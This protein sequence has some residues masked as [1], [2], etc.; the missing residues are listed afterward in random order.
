MAKLFPPILEGT[1]PAFYSENGIVKITIPFSMNR[2]VSPVQVKGLVL[3]IKTVQSSSYL[4]TAQINNELYFDLENSP[5]VEFTFGKDSTNTEEN[6]FINNLKVGQ[7]YKFQLAYLG[8][9]D[10]VGHYS[11]VAIGK[12]TTKPNLYINNLNANFINTHEYKYI[13][14]YS[15]RNGDITERVYSYRFDIYDYN[16]KIIATSGEQLHNSS[17]DTELDESY[18]EF[19]FSQDLEL[20]KPYRVKYT[21]TTVN[22]LTISSYRYR[23]MQ[24][25]TIDPEVKASLKASANYDN[26]YINVSLIGDKDENGMEE[27]ATGAFL[28]TRACEDSNYTIWDEISR[29]KLATQIPSRQLWRDYTIEQGK[30]YIYSLQQYNDNGLYSNRMLSNTVFG[31]FEDAFLFDGNRQLKIKY[32][33]KMSNFKAD[34][35]ET[36]IDTI[37][38]KHP[39][40]FRNGKVYYREFAISGLISY[41]MDEENLFLSEEESMIKEKTTNLTSEN[42]AQERNFKMKVYEWLTDGKPKLFRSPSEGN[43][44]VRL[45][46]VSM[47]PN[48]T[49][50]RMLHTFNA[51]AYEIAE[52][53]YENLNE[54]D[55]IHLKDPEVPQLRWETI[56]FNERDEQGKFV[57]LNGKLNKHPVYTVR[58]VDMIPGDQFKIILENDDTQ[59]IQ[60]GVTGSYYIDLGV[61]IKS[62]ELIINEKNPLLREGSMTYSYYSIQSNI[63]DKISNVTVSEVP[64]R[65]FI[66]HHDV[67]KE[68]EYV[69]DKENDKWYKNPK[70][71]IIE[72]YN[73]YASKRTNEKIIEKDNIYY[74]DKDCRIPLPDSKD[75]FTLYQVGTWEATG[76]GSMGP[77]YG[78][79]R[80]TYKFTIKS[81]KDFFNDKEYLISSDVNVYQPFI[82]INNSQISLNDTQVFTMDKPGKLSS[83]KSGNGTVVEV[84]YQVRN[85]DYNIEDDERNYP[86]LFNAKKDYLETLVDFE[87]YLNDDTN[88]GEQS[89]LDNYQKD[90]NIKYNKYILELIKAQEEEK[91]AEGLI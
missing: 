24:K 18:D 3:K 30:N 78:P 62:I 34:I 71:D 85:I 40:I 90:L 79:S 32:N 2:A 47:T 86:S 58:L 44:I 53:N 73:L 9:D 23:I 81:Y 76:S 38:S 19:L 56:K 39:F 75:I 50:G 52:Y 80:P 74:Q 26:G 10:K 41:Y 1:I 55:F 45:M 29:F 20:N 36:K 83:L 17:N 11:T 61:P 46:N 8:L 63:F 22:G 21:I 91:K 72:F 7:F 16:N 89:I 65:Q 68:I 42:L 28:L 27:P 48:D 35:M 60:I 43:F 31:D 66:G 12:Y 64:V 49:V 70:I 15:Q 13:G 69:Y 59:I 51:T 54:F 4:Y 5:W 84:S 67:I 14:Y 87:E 37:G 33:P 82:E 57:Y 77:G 88:L 25:L 6:N